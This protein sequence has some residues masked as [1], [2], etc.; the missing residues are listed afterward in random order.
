[1]YCIRRYCIKGIATDTLYIVYVDTVLKVYHRY[2]IYCIRRYC[3]KSIATDTLYIV[4]VDTVLK[5]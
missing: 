2:T 5:V 3:I 1:M 4:Y